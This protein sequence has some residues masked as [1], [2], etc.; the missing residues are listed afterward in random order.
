[1]DEIGTFHTAP[2]QQWIANNSPIKIW[3]DNVDKKRGVRDKRSDHSGELLHMYTIVATQSRTRANSLK[4]TGCVA[5][6]VF[7]TNI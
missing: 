2:L 3:G 6:L 1:M 4:H 7:S 5:D